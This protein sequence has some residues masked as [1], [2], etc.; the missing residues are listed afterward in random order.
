MRQLEG[1]WDMS[2]R[3][4][5]TFSCLLMDI[6][7]F[8][9]FNDTYGH[10]V[11]DSVLRFVAQSLHKTCRKGEAAFRVGGEEFLVICP[12]SNESEAM[13]AGERLRQFIASN[14]L[15]VDDQELGVHISVGVATRS[16]SLNNIDEL[17][18]L[19]DSHLYA[20]K[21]AGRNCVCAST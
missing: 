6:N 3:H 20:A 5:E 1:F 17:L 8:K 7:H 12:R 13:L 14:T 16:D 18:A 19:A 10:A 11:G 9:Q 15:K 2:I 4:N 21:E